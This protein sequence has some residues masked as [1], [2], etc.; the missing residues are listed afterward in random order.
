[1]ITIDVMIVWLISLVV[2]G[3]LSFFAGKANIRVFE[4][5]STDEVREL[6]QTNPDYDE[7]LKSVYE[8]EA[9]FVPGIDK[10][11][12]HEEKRNILYKTFGDF[13]SL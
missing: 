8:E 11:T 12:S 4:V 6:T 13:E 7:L 3:V 10:D 9:A 2:I 1:M 5:R